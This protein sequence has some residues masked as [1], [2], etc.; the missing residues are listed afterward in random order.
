MELLCC[1]P[2]CWCGDGLPG[3]KEAEGRWWL[4]SGITSPS[5]FILGLTSYR[6]GFIFAKLSQVL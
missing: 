1:K 3:L 5:S 6:L 2:V 4:V